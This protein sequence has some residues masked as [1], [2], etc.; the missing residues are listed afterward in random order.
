VAYIIAT[1]H[2]KQDTACVDVCRWIV[3]IGEGSNL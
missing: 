2:W 3:F 1:L